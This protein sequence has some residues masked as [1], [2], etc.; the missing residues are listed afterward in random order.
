MSQS[1]TKIDI[2]TWHGTALLDGKILYFSTKRQ[3][4]ASS[5]ARASSSVLAESEC[6]VVMKVTTTLRQITINNI[7]QIFFKNQYFI[8]Y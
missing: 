5:Q 1:E 6:N 2:I 8:R 3:E 4:C 7:T